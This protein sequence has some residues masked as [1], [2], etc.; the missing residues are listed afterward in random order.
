MDVAGDARTSGV[1]VKLAH[2][3][4]FSY[5]PPGAGSSR[6][7][8]DEEKKEKK[9][10]QEQ[11]QQQIYQQQQERAIKRAERHAERELREIQQAELLA[12]SASLV[13]AVNQSRECRRSNSL[14]SM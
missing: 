5:P 6:S 2:Q 1:R 11:Q 4:W 14:Q 9:D 8:T 12:A 7:Q 10:L 13:E 3:F